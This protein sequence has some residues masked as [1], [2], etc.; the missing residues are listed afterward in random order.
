MKEIICIICPYECKIR[1]DDEGKISNYRCKKGLD[2]VKDELYNPKRSF[3]TTLKVVGFE[4]RRLAV[5]LDKEIPKDKIFEVL[6]IL[7]KIKIEKKV[8]R[9]E[10]IL[11]NALNLGSNVISSETIEE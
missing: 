7:K 5:R 4:K 11:E 9:G 3:T 1:I 10:I 2:Y 8:K 6:K